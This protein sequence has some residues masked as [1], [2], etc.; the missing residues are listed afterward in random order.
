MAAH[1]LGAT[2]VAGTAEAIASVDGQS[3][4]ICVSELDSPKQPCVR[5]V[6][7]TGS[8]VGAQVSLGC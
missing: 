4:S 2:V 6:V 5:L 8:I 1:S 7:A 3:I